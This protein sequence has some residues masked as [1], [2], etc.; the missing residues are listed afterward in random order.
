MAAD[1]SDFVHHL[2]GDHLATATDTGLLGRYATE[3]DD[4]AFAELVHRYAPAVYAQCRRHLSDPGSLDDAFQ[5]TFV[6]LARKAGTLTHPERLCSW[7]CGVAD[8]IARKARVRNVKRGATEQ[9]LDTADEPTTT[10]PTSDADLRAVLDQELNALPPDLRQLVLLCDVGGLSR[11]AAAKHLGI[12]V[13]TLSNRLT[14]ARAILGSRLLHRGVALGA[15]LTLTAVITAAVPPQLVPLTVSRIASGAVPPSVTLLANEGLKMPFVLRATIAVFIGLC[16]AGLSLVTLT[17]AEPPKPPS[18][19]DKPADPPEPDDPTP[20]DG[21]LAFGA[22]YSRD[23]KLLALAEMIGGVKKTVYRVTVF[24]A[25]TWKVL[26]HLSGPTGIPRAVAFTADGKTVFASGDDG[27]V[28]SWDVKTGKAGMKLEAKAGACGA[29]VLSPDGKLLATAHQ[30][31]KNKKVKPRL[32][33]WDVATGKVVHSLENDEKLVNQTVSF[34]PDGKRL[35]GAYGAD[36]NQSDKFHGLIEWD[37]ET[38]KEVKRID[39]PRITPGA[40]PI[41]QRVA[42]TADGSQVIVAG[43]EAV[44]DGTGGCSCLGYLWLIDHKSGKV[45]KTLIENDREDYVRQMALSVDGKRMYVGRGIPWVVFAL[46]KPHTTTG[47]ELQCWD[48]TKWEVEWAQAGD[49]THRTWAFAA[50][51]NGKR[52]AVSSESGVNLLDPTTGEK[53]GGLTAPTTPK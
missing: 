36:L 23:G 5:A 25:T 18:V 8:R 28:Y 43:G 39:I 9:P 21:G 14:R 49:F 7:L 29:V 12:P 2:R 11:R 13:G 24:D 37:V 17:A 41:V 47:A 16:I 6:V 19:V 46:G 35:L 45:A 50:A 40:T 48:T 1:L 26:H 51:P 20:I 34:S 32:V 15:G 31:F 53:R 38:G 52:V 22:T 44:P 10:D 4:L 27:V 42:Y 33:V 30:H 3:R